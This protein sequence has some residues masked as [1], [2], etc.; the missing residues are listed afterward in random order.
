MRTL[1]IITLLLFS[2]CHDNAVY[3]EE[4]TLENIELS[5]EVYMAPATYQVSD[6]SDKE[7]D[8]ALSKKMIKTGGIDFQSESVEKDYKKICDLL[9]KYNAFI[10]SERQSKSSYQINYNLTIRVP[11]KV[12]DT[13]YHDIS[14]FA[15]KLDNRYSNV[16]DV[17]NQYY[18]LQTRIKNK[19]ILEERYLKLLD[20]ATLIK[21]MLEIERNINNIRT[22]IERLQSQFNYLS[23][24]VSYSTIDL[25]FYEVLPYVYD[26]TNRE[27]FGARVLS[28][29]DDGW[30]GFL[31]FIVGL[32][33]AWPVVIIISIS[34]YMIR[35][36]KFNWR[37]FRKKTT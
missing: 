23:K 14:T 22:D 35:K 9:P 24:Q 16:E 6:G 3:D 15:F 25:N 20:K 13:L 37:K 31:S 8:I 18:D 17:T 29:L 21:D 19:K 12:Y 28:A 2:A 26:K 11:S 10:E 36:I 33:S 5:E 27:G 4:V 7:S 1:S 34:I 32:T 30:Q